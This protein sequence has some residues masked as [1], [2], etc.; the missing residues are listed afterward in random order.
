MAFSYRAEIV[1]YIFSLDVK[2]PFSWSVYSSSLTNTW[3]QRDVQ[4]QYRTLH[5]QRET[6]GSNQILISSTNCR[7]YWDQV[8]ILTKSWDHLLPLW[9][10]GY[11]REKCF[12]QRAH[13]CKELFSVSI[14]SPELSIDPQQHLSD[15]PYLFFNDVSEGFKFLQCRKSTSRQANKLM[16]ASIMRKSSSPWR[17]TN[18]NSGLYHNQ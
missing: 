3:N 9:C 14:L 15:A 4:N 7:W 5:L 10:Q 13:S 6:F 2:V 16:K 1:A 18:V 17:H 11:D 8:R 12:C